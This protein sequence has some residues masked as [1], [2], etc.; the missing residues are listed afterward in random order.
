MNG[1]TRTRGAVILVAVGFILLGGAL[2]TTGIAQE[3]DD[4]DT[5]SIG[6]LA[7][8]IEDQYEETNT[9][10]SLASSPV[11]PALLGGGLGLGLGAIGGAG[12]ASQN[13]GMR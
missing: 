1:G 9:A 2:A 7:D 4:D 13:R 12:F 8:E 10:V 6:A 5:R 11:A 3:S